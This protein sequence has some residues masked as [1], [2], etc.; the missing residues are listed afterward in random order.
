[1][2]RRQYRI[3]VQNKSPIIVDGMGQT[4]NMIR[5]LDPQ[6]YIIELRDHTAIGGWKM[7]VT[8]AESREGRD[9]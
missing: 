9:L 3:Q 4:I 2:K 8:A 7:L 1:M 5:A 6:W